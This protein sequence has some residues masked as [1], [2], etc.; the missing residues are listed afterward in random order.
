MHTMWPKT[1]SPS[2]IQ[3]RG[4]CWKQAPTLRGWSATISQVPL[5]HVC[6][7]L[8]TIPH[9][10]LQELTKQG[11][12][13]MVTHWNLIQEPA[14]WP[15]PNLPHPHIPRMFSPDCSSSTTF[16]TPHLRSSPYCLKPLALVTINQTLTMVLLGLDPL[17]HPFFFQAGHP[18]THE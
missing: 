9:R 12:G 4:R 10:L 16:S 2:V 13:Y 7:W 5:G 1:G 17:S 15:L 3:N 18:W 11:T 14:N 6:N 8:S